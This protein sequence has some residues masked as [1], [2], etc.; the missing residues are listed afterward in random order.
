M[1]SILAI[2]S[3]LGDAPEH[4]VSFPIKRNSQLIEGTILTVKLM[5]TT[6]HFML[7]DWSKIV[8]KAI[9]AWGG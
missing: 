6:E 5:G 1:L 2:R 9:S 8:E 4:A 3:S 7:L